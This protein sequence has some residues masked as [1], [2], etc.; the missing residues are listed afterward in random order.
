MSQLAGKPAAQTVGLARAQPARREY[1]SAKPFLLLALL[2]LLGV[3][4]LLSLALG[5]ASIPLEQIVTVVLG[6]QADHESW[7]NII[8]KF[9]LPKTAT[10][11]LA[12]MA[13]G[14][15]GL[16]MQTYFRNPLAEPFVLG[17]SSGASLG[18]AL[19]VLGSGAVGGALLAGLGLAGDLLLT[20]AAGAGA[21]LS[22][23]LVLLVAA[24]VRSGVTLL[25]LGLMFGYLVGAMVSLLLYFALPERIQ[26]YVNWTFGSFS[27]VTAAQLP[28]LAFFV[29]SGLLLSAALVKPLNALLLGEDYARSLGIHLQWTRF[30][31]ILATALL[32]SAVTAF[33]GPIAFLGIAVPHLCRGL[34]G[35]SDHRLLL[36][37]ACLAGACV[38][39]CAALIAEL[40]G[41]NLVLPLNVV[42]ALLGAP[43]VMLVALRHARGV[44]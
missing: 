10:A 7:T 32:V 40:P 28:I 33:C 37:G 4:L 11:A 42:T 35:S 5:S 18:V 38:A 36:P 25:L 20:A 1:S 34:L 12:G 16:L 29:L 21:A 14:V 24:R 13:L 41:N 44:A 17:V 19:V 30:L 6:G 15:S 22:M 26:A 8:L 2:A 31:I 27:G 23:T 43:V 39:L 3:L 9:R